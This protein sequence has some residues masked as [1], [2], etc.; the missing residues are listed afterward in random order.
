MESIYSYILETSL[1]VFE[2][3]FDEESKLGYG[4]LGDV[5][6]GIL[7]ATGRLC[8]IK[9][10]IK[11]KMGDKKA[12]YLLS[13][14]TEIDLLSSLS[15][16]FVTKIL[17]KFQDKNENYYLVTE[18]GTEGDLDKYFKKVFQQSDDFPKEFLRY[19]VMI[20]LAI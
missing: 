12:K 8:A 15:R 6:N 19:F 17:D 4:G 11:P 1:D 9:K 5:Y 7:K 20:V 10:F 16:P 18:L 13:F 2:V 3:N 14:E